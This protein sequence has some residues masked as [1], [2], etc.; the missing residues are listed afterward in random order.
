MKI[1]VHMEWVKFSL[2]RLVHEFLGLTLA[3]IVM[4]FF[5]NVNIFLLLFDLPQKFMQNYIIEWK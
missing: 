3:I 4:I 5:C 2:K 1:Y